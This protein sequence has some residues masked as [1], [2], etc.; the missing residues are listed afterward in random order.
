VQLGATINQELPGDSWG[1]RVEL[2]SDGDILA[3][4]AH[5]NDGFFGSDA[6][7]VRVYEWSGSSWVQL[8]AD[9]DGEAGNDQFGDSLSL[10]GDGTRVAAGAWRNG[11]NGVQA[12]HA[13]VYEWSG[14]SWVQMGADIDAEASGDE[15]G[16]SI[17]LSQD[18][19]VLAVGAIENDGTDN[20]AGHVRV[21]QYSASSWV[22]LGDDIDGEAASDNFGKSVALSQDGLVLAVGASGNDGSYNN[23]GH[24]RVYLYSSSSWVQFGDDIDGEAASDESGTSIAL[25]QD[26]GLLAVGAPNNGGKGQVR[27]FEGLLTL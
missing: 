18:G 3:A 27:T 7:H 10:S 2:S 4:S 17:A 11:G 5:T 24:V 21:Y 19:A 1:R 25:S 20:N 23:A 12:G 6:G 9:I 16:I 13:R 14:S 15:F 26:G 22:Q 8:G